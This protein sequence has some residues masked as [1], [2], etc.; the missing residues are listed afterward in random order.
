MTILL[1]P[2]IIIR[3]IVLKKPGKL[4]LETGIEPSFSSFCDREVKDEGFLILAVL[5]KNY[6]YTVLNSHKTKTKDEHLIHALTSALVKFP[7][8]LSNFFT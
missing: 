4:N 7:N 8:M 3:I 5:K 2:L 6:T 1:V